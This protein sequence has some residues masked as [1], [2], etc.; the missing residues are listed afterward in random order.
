MSWHSALPCFQADIYSDRV[1]YTPERLAKIAAEASKENSIFSLDDRM[2][3]LYD[4]NALSKAGLAKLSDTLTVIDLWSNEKE[5]KSMLCM[6]P[7]VSTQLFVD[8]VLSTVAETLGSLTATFW[9]SPDTVEGIRAL[10][11]VRILFC[12]GYHM[13]TSRRPC[14]FR[15]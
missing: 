5:C 14:L 13:L 15:L 2:G 10:I 11:R 7:I 1:L 8:L 9:E 4:V 3:I 6:V 12:S